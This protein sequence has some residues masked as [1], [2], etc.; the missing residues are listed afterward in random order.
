[1]ASTVI[2]AGHQVVGFYDD[3]PETWRRPVLGI[4]VAGP[5]S[6]LTRG[7][8]SRAI[9]GIGDNQTRKRLAQAM[10]LDWLTAVHP[11][12]YVHPTARLGHGTVVCAGAIVQPGAEVGAHVIINT[13]ASVD[14]HCRVG[15]YVHIAVAHLGGEASA[16][17][18][19]FLALGA[20]V[21]PGIHVGAWATVGAGAVATK[22]V[23]PGITVVGIPAR[24]LTS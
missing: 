15:D 7:V 3:D 22:D 6:E 12:S 11:F 19:A 14:H 10:D 16:D 8:C 4:P 17:E 2:A 23:A 5:L 18:G 13:K 21:L 24:P 20:I 9:I 1:V